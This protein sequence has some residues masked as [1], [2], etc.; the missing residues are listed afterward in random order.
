Q[1]RIDVDLAVGGVGDRHVALAGGGEDAVGV[2]GV[3]VDQAG[4]VDGGP[5]HARDLDSAAA[6][7]LGRHGDRAGVAGAGRI[8]LGRGHHAV[9]GVH[10]QCAGLHRNVAGV[11]GAG[12]AVERQRQGAVGHAARVGLDAAGV[13]HARGAVGRRDQ[14]DGAGTVVLGVLAGVDRAAVAGAGAAA[15]AERERLDARG[16]V[17]ALGDDVA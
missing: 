5:G 1:P 10:Q 12:L 15:R 11:G 6:I 13:V 2:L 17:V 4:V 8:V 14:A 16:A 3:H 9:S 7:D